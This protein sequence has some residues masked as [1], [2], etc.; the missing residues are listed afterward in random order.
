MQGNSGCIV[1]Q[2]YRAPGMVKK[3]CNGVY[4]IHRLQAQMEKQKWFYYNGPVPCPKVLG[5]VEDGGFG[6]LMD[7][8]PGDD[9]FSYDEYQLSWF[10]AEIVRYFNWLMKDKEFK[11]VPAHIFNK[12]MMQIQV[13]ADIQIPY[14]FSSLS[15][16]IGWCHGD[17]TLENIIPQHPETIVLVDFL[18]SFLD[19]PWLDIVKLRQDT[20]H[21]WILRNGGT[22]Q[23]H[24]TLNYLD[25]CFRHLISK[26]A[27]VPLQIL[28]LAR[29]LPYSNDADKAFVMKEIECL[30]QTSRG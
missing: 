1:E 2:W 13:A 30:I 25:D 4:P 22:E 8:E 20:K 10:I 12:K 28:N 9:I 19:S 15:L 17:L 7:Y 18:D 11:E 6:F 14:I 27:Y 29:I 16:P 3:H 21:K 26:E 23:Q 5:T 24:A